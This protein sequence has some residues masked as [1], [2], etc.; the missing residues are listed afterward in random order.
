MRRKSTL[1]KT[2]EVCGT[3]IDRRPGE[4][5]THY[6][7]RRACSFA[8]RSVLIAGAHRRRTEE[9]HAAPEA[10]KPCKRCGVAFGLRSNEMPA[11]FR[12]R[13]YCS[14]EC[15]RI[16]VADA[17]RT[18]PKEKACHA[19]GVIFERRRGEASIC[20]RQRKYCSQSCAWSHQARG[21][22]PIVGRYGGYYPVDW[23]ERLRQE[24]RDR[25]G[26]CRLCGKTPT[27]NGTSLS[28]HHVNYLRHDLCKENLVALCLACHGKTN[29]NRPYW[30]RLF[31]AMMA[32]Q[33]AAA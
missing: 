22:A 24:I 8:C 32:D 21:S 2:C 18:T 25:D 11:Q 3:G 9:A 14:D 29:A 10:M 4:Q 33:E 16:A 12:R 23:T 30:L 19:C 7:R 15:R 17:T 5:A 6:E 13:V 31:T 27:E 28:V 1:P 20:W 26:V